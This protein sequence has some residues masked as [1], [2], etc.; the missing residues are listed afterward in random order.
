MSTVSKL[1]LSSQNQGKITE[2]SAM[3]APLGIQVVSA[4]N[5]ALPNVEETGKT[6]A[7]NAE[8]KARAGYRATGLPTLA[9]DSGLCVDIL[10]GAPGVYTARFGG[11]NKLITKLAS[12]TAPEARSAQFICHLT[13]VLPN[14]ENSATS[15]PYIH[16]FTGKTEGFITLKSKGSK[17]FGYDPVFSLTP[18]GTT[19]AEMTPDKKALTSHRGQALRTLKKFLV[20]SI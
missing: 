6:F 20:E 18:N 19:Y 8:L 7:E 12:H 13:L 1:L 2:L 15:D 4:L 11:P 10:D 3:L 14:P 9:D 17:G 16:H 5:L